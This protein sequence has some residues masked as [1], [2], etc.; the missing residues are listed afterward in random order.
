MMIPK[1]AYRVYVLTRNGGDL[2]SENHNYE[3]LSAAVDFRD[4]ALRKPRTKK[5][6]IVCVLDESTPYDVPRT[7]IRSSDRAQPT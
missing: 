3:T 2:H 1:Y 7:P 5:V 6:E 4:I